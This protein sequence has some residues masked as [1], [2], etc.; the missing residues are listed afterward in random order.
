MRRSPPATSPRRYILLSMLV[1]VLDSLVSAG[2]GGGPSHTVQIPISTVVAPLDAA[3]METLCA[4]QI[5]MC[6]VSCQNKIQQNSCEAK[7]LS[8]TCTCK[9]GTRSTF[10]D[11]QLPIPFQLCRRQLS[12]CLQQ[13]ESSQQQTL[14]RERKAKVSTPSVRKRKTG[15]GGSRDN[16]KQEE[17]IESM[18]IA[19]EFQLVRQSARLQAA[20][21]SKQGNSRQ[22][23]YQR[24]Q[25]QSKQQMRKRRKY[26][27]K[28]RLLEQSTSSKTQHQPPSS[29]ARGAS[30]KEEKSARGA[31]VETGTTITATKGKDE[32][33]QQPPSAYSLDTPVPRDPIC[34]AQCEH[35]FSCGTRSAPEYRNLNDY[36]AR[37]NTP[38]SDDDG[39]GK[40]VSRS[41]SNGPDSG[42]L[43][44]LRLSM[45]VS[46]SIMM[47]SV[48]VAHHVTL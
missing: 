43:L 34:A 16:I 27:R 13:C 39:R 42:G 32:V 28:K 21:F 40:A 18:D 36:L 37:N 33:I 30:T 31:G 20:S 8:W 22:L 26:A 25:L 2:A 4:D 29:R 9:D 14:D 23:K 45:L 5:G 7:T 6:T 1:M 10:A 12:A 46:V 38:G 44:D 35:Q 48:V 3:A 15:S 11:W 47:V 17:R 24:L 41:K 19:D